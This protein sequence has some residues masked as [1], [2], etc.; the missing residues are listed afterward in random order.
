MHNQKSPDGASP[1]QVASSAAGA[2]AAKPATPGMAAEFLAPNGAGSGSPNGAGGGGPQA[3][4]GFS[5]PRAGTRL[6]LGSPSAGVARLGSPG[7]GLRSHGNLAHGGA[8]ESLLLRLRQELED[9]LR[10]ALR[11]MKE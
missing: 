5:T 11:S 8:V 9:D 6:Q 1:G 3:E 4:P 7:S 10:R 2:S